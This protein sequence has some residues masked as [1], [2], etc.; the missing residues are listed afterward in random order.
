MPARLLAAVTCL[1]LAAPSFGQ[2]TVQWRSHSGIPVAVVEVPGGDLEHLVLVVPPDTPLPSELLGHA[3]MVT[4][5]PGASVWTL[6]APKLLAVVA[7]REAFTQLAAAGAALAIGPV[8]FRDLRSAFEMLD[9]V[10]FRPPPAQRCVVAD[11]T[12]DVVRGDEERV[13]LAFAAPS[14]AAPDFPLSEALAAWLRIRLLPSF[15]GLR[16]DREVAQ[17]CSRV[18]VTAPAGEMEPRQA[19][20]RLRGAVR[21]VVASPAA[22]TEVD[23]VSGALRRRSTR[24]ATAGASVGRELA[25]QLAYGASVSS[26][27]APPTVTPET[28]AGIATTVLESRSGAA[29]VVEREQRAAPPEVTTLDNGV[30]VSWR[31]IPGDVAVAAIAFAGVAPGAGRAAARHVAEVTSAAGWVVDVVELLG[32][33]LVAVAVPAVDVAAALERMAAALD[34][35]PVPAVAPLDAALADRL[36]LASRPAAEQLALALAL[37]TEAEEAPEAAAKFFAGLTSGGVRSSGTSPAGPLLWSQGPPP[38]GVLAVAELPADAAGLVAGT[39][40]A[41]RLAPEGIVSG[42]VAAP[43]RL[44]LRLAAEGAAD[45]PALEAVQAAAWGRART[46]ATESELRTAA[47]ELAAHLDGDLARATA[48]A[49]AAHFL[50]ALPAPESLFSVESGAVAEI[51]AALPPWH[52]LVRVASGPAPAEPAPGDVR[53]SRPRRR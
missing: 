52:E 35:L 28:L 51:L 38:A 27:V 1:A 17:G 4:T 24:W 26:L 37:P 2:A 23:R 50:P 34:A 33:D 13:E 43:G 41:S 11:G 7:A 25:E 36:G 8:P 48:R 32:L 42:W 47:S 6:S 18:L 49:A 31:W 29:R 20:Q 40:L 10:A 39:V 19:L 3:A 46:A 5:Q 15:P 44:L 21:A 53:Q 14:P 22:P 12:L 9:S 45:V 30:V 16:V